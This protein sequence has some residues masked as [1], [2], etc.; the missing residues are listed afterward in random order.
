[1]LAV[2][3]D[4]SQLLLIIALALAIAGGVIAGIARAWAVVL[5]AASAALVCLTLLF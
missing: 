2:T 1:M 3:H 4:T 5:V